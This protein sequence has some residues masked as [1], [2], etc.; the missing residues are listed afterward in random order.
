MSTVHATE[1]EFGERSLRYAGWRVAL[2][3][4]ACAFVSFASV[5]IYTFGIFLKPLTEQFHWSREAVSAGFSIA[6]L[7]V[8]ACSPAIGL[9]LDRL[10]PRRIFLPCLA[11]F[12][13]AFISLATLTPQL[14]RLYATCV[15]LGVVGNGTAYLAYSRVLSTWF[16]A[17]LGAAFALLMSGGAIGAIVLPPA[18]QALVGAAGWRYSFVI[19]GSMILAIGLPM[20]MQIRERAGVARSSESPVTGVS[21]GAALRSR[22]FWII[23]TVL[24]FSSISQNGAIAHLSALLTD[25]GIPSSSA[26]LAV[27]SLG[28]A[29]LAGRILT[30][31]LLDRYFAPRVSFCLLTAAAVGTFLVSHAHSM[32][33]GMLGAALIGIGMGAE[34]DIT[35]Y[36]LSRYFGLRSF[37]VLYG[38]TWTAYAIAGAIG[39]MMMGKAFDEHGSYEALLTRLSVLTFAGGALMLF[40]PR[41]SHLGR[42]GFATT[43]MSTAA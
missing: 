17:R 10:P 26:A 27:S 2:A 42:G 37:S 16:Q 19:L 9:L 29:T 1:R 25:R 18:T 21:A 23:V 36:L 22:I 8:A 5:F 43:E 4:S 24:F 31:W 14:W 39:P 15:V 3:S 13:C 28:G 40:L 20:G 38:L 30:G 6:A 41:Y 35:P 12:G 33:T 34:A 7:S 32:L 11:V